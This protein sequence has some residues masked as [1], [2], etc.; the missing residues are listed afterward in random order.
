MLGSTLRIA[1]RNLGR[2]RRRTALALAA[3][4][5]AQMSVLLVDGLMHG[6]VDSTL[7]SLTGPM[8][9]H[10][11]VHHPEWREEQAPDLA[12]DDLEAKLAAVR[13]TEGVESAFA[14]LYGPALAAREVDGFPVLVI[15]I[16][17]DSERAQDGLLQ[18]LPP[19]AAPEPGTVLVGAILAREQGL[20]VGDEIAIMGTAADGSIANDLWT[21]SG[22]L[23]TPV[24]QIGRQGLLVPLA[25][26][27]EVFAMPDMAHEITIHG[28][29]DPSQARAL[30]DRVGAADGLAE[31]E[32]LAWDELAPEL[33]QFFQ[34]A[35]V[36]GFF[37]M[38]IVFLAAAA[39]VAN[40]MLM[41]TFERR[42]ELGMLLALGLTPG[43]LVRMIVFEAVILGLLGVLIGSLIG[44]ALVAWQG[45]V[46]INFYGGGEDTA[47]IAMYGVSFTEALYPRLAV[48]DVVP[49]FVGICVVSIFSALW[50]ALSAAR[51]EPVEAM[52]G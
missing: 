6:F 39:G 4:A 44:G 2:N 48:G 50:P 1:W 21:V 13:A 47:Q 26:A 23:A 46:G 17:V 18:G 52:R 41:A 28:V 51:L 42:R 24:D 45:A 33:A 7:E 8:T 38:F 37:V 40:T 49:G 9:G 11:Q 15:G 31:L 14:R 19:E 3:I 36:Y 22:L 34:I 29:G 35:G 32:V 25:T 10:A 43:R 20:E 27:Q 16:D 30:A 5:I 12:I